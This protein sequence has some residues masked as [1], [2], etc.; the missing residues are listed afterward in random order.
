MYLLNECLSSGSF[1]PNLVWANFMP[2]KRLPNFDLVLG[3]NR[4]AVERLLSY[5][6]GRYVCF[7]EYVY[8]Y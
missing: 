5:F 2:N 1:F 8:C 4:Y 6:V 3:D 7:Y